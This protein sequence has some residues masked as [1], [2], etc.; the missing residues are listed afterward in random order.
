MPT[1]FRDWVQFE[2]WFD[3]DD[4]ADQEGTEAF[5]QDDKKQA[6]IKKMHLILQPL[7]L[8]RIKADV[9]HLLPKKREYVLYAPLT[10]DQIQ[11]YDAIN[12]KKVDT[13]QFLE[14]KVIERLTGATNIPAISRT[15]TPKVESSDSEDLP[16]S[17][18]AIKNN[19]RGRPAKSAAS[20]PKNAFTSM[21]G[22][23]SV[24]SPAASSPAPS[25][26]KRKSSESLKTPASKSAKSSRASTPARS[27]RGRKTATRMTYEEGNT[28]DENALSDD[29]FEAKLAD[30]MALQNE[31]P[32]VE[33]DPEE[34]ERLSIIEQAKKEISNKKLGNPIMQLRLACNT[35]H[36]FYSPRSTDQSISNTLIN[37]SGKMLLLDRLLP[38]LFAKGSK[39]LIFSQFKI[40]LD[41]L[42]DYAREL[43]GWNVC[44]IDG[45]VAQADRQERIRAFNEDPEFKLFLLSTR[46]GGQGINLATAD[47]VILFDSDWNPQQDLQAQDRAHRIGQ[48][49]PVIVYR[50]ATKG[51]VEEELLGSADA[52]RRLEKLVIKK[53]GFKTM[54]Q[55]MADEGMTQ[56]A[57][58]ALML[59]DGE[60]FRVKGGQEVLSQRDLEVLTDRSDAAYKRAE[61]GAGDSEAFKI[62]E[63]KA[64]GLMMGMERKRK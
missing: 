7:L 24:A 23:K 36:L 32:T 29:E 47:T 37:S 50:L 20:T 62:V 26:R 38:H 43:K 21:M 10:R 51:T 46:A 11:L 15:A 18:L 1:I 16:L 33:S 34:T 63:T 14:N 48:K 39:V 13:R 59:K 44:R 58:K 55:K 9:E 49:N 61:D 3:F 56:E 4:L 22:N 17:K 27:T 52:K 64:E 42:E 54:G 53:G 25:S 31:T 45:S 35:P 6:L 2:S 12:D 41:L 19:A 30:E 8:R 40:Q 5:L 28:D 60:V 57:L